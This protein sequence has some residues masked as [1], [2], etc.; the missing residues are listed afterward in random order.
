MDLPNAEIKL[1]FP[2]LQADSLQTEPPG[3]PKNTR[4]GSLSL[5]GGDL[6][7]PGIELGSPALQADSLPT[8]LS[9][10]VKKTIS[11]VIEKDSII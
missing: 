8:E 5:L 6:S 11:C 3:K 10:C 9:E 4:V 1:G 2:A 7:D